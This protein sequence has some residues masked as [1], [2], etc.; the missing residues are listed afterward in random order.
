MA[1]TVHR[2][3]RPAVSCTLCRRRKIRCN[4][5][6]PCSNCIRSGS[7]PCVYDAPPPPRRAAGSNNHNNTAASPWPAAGARPGTR[8]PAGAGPGSTSV[9]CEV[10]KQAAPGVATLHSSLSPSAATSASSQ[11]QQQQQPPPPQ[12]VHDVI[13]EMSSRIAGSFHMAGHGGSKNKPAIPRI[14]THKQRTFGQSHWITASLLF[15]DLIELIEPHLQ[16]GQNNDATAG[17]RRCKT[18]ARIVK[19]RRAPAWPTV[20]TPDLPDRRTADALVSCYLR[21]SERLYRVL[22]IPSFTRDYE[23]LWTTTHD[24]ATGHFLVQLK[25]VLVIGTVTHDATF[26]L[27]GHATRWIYEAQ[28]WLAE[29]KFKSRLLTLQSVQTHILLLLAEEL[30]AVGGDAVWIGAGALLR[31]AVHL[32]LHRDPSHLPRAS[33]LVTEMRRRLWNTILEL[34]MQFCVAGGTPPGMVLEDFDT[35]PPGNFDDEQLVGGGSGGGGAAAAGGG[36]EPSPKPESVYTQTSLALALRRTLPVRLK[37]ARALN[38]VRSTHGTY[39]QML[40]LDGELRAAY[41]EMG[42]TLQRYK[43]PA[44]TPSSFE[45]RAIDLIMQRYLCFLHIPYIQASLHEKAYAYSRKAALESSMKVWYLVFPPRAAATTTT[46]TTTP[47]DNN[48]N[49]V[50]DEDLL[51][52]FATNGHGLFRTTVAKVSTVVAKEL[53]MQRLED[54]SVI[55]ASPASAFHIPLRPDLIAILDASRAWHRRTLESGETNMKG[56]LLAHAAM[57]YVDVMARGELPDLAE[58]LVLVMIK[59]MGESIE[60]SIPILE[61]E[62]AKYGPPVVGKDIEALAE[63]GGREKTRGELDGHVIGPVVQGTEISTGGQGGGG[64]GGAAEGDA[65]W[66]FMV[67]FFFLPC[68]DSAQC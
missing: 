9:A 45:L 7:A 68:C 11:Q 46:T 30:V 55:L 40:R 59:A 51:A 2:R 57:S 33:L 66:D 52:R 44:G 64:G 19:A 21:T 22:H 43:A 34:N 24:P 48:N 4:R 38:N 1:D 47:S 26:S 61:A 53:R 27:R 42:V 17:L 63:L 23:A 56:F 8:G 5:E 31:R 10:W 60:L 12:P 18:L 54:T 25:L 29:P 36:K 37:A 32:G 49:D 3:R 58:E 62:A 67:S 6:A 65:G 41:R 50:D 16:A 28:T 15:W 20:P 35:L 14:V 39:E 13:D